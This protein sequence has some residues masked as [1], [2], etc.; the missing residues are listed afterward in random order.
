[1]KFL[2]PQDVFDYLPEKFNYI[3]MNPEGYW[4]AV[5]NTP[6]L[7]WDKS[8]WN[9][10][11]ESEPLILNIEYTGDWKNSLFCRE[12]QISIYDIPQTSITLSDLTKCIK[13]H[14]IYEIK[15]KENFTCVHCFT[16][17]EK[18]IEAYERLMSEQT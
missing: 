13:C 15:K 9:P 17:K 10:V 14:G 11:K 18:Y 3:L 7:N 8:C 5:A 4:S 16:L 6:S 12:K 2:Q 1:M